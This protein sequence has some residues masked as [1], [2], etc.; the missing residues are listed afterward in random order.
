MIKLCYGMKIISAVLVVGG[1]G[2]L[3]LDNIDMWTF[4]CQSLLGVTMWLLSSKWE[5]EIAFYE[6]KKSPLVK[7]VEEV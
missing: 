2:S 1:M 6:N 7:S 3:E 4:I 5:E